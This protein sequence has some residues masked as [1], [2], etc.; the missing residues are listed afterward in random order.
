M[1]E[2]LAGRHGP[3]SCGAPLAGNRP[4]FRRRTR[5][6]SGKIFDRGIGDH[7]EVAKGTGRRT[8]RPKISARNLSK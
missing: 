4:D 5:K 6:Q 3:P 2:D 7:G 1:V 8:S